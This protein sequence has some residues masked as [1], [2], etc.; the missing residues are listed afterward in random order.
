MIHQWRT[1]I[2]LIIVIVIISLIIAI[3]RL[4]IIV[5]VKH[6]KRINNYTIT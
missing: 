3:V 2:K 1:I 4:I 5:A 6:L